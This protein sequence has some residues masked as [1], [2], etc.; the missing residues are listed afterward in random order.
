MYRERDSKSLE[1]S[2]VLIQRSLGITDP[3]TCW[4]NA[5]AGA[6]ASDNPLGVGRD[7]IDLA[8]RKDSN[9]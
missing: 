6:S 7:A 8:P 5:A 2:V 3:H 1:S 4:F 9:L